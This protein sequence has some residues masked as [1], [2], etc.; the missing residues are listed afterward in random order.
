MGWIND[1]GSP[2]LDSDVG[3]SGCRIEAR[4]FSISMA[5]EGFWFESSLRTA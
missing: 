3:W 5:A 2:R 4:A 1:L